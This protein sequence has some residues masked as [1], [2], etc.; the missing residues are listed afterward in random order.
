MLIGTGLLFWIMFKNLLRQISRAEDTKHLNEVSEQRYRA[1]L[2]GN[3]G[4][5][6]EI[7]VTKNSA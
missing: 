1:A 4:G 3:R 6:F 7:N 5:I 2:E